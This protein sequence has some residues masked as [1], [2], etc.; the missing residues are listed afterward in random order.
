MLKEKEQ[1]PSNN[2]SIKELVSEWIDNKWILEVVVAVEVVVVV[3]VVN[4]SN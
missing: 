4:S 2:Y 3:I 1:I